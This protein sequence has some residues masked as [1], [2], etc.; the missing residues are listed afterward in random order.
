MTKSNKGQKPS[1]DLPLR[2]LRCFI[3]VIRGDRYADAAARLGVTSS[4]VS[5]QIRTLE[6]WIGG[7]LLS[8]ETKKPL[9][10]ELG[11][12]LHEG[13]AEPMAR[14]ERVMAAVQR[15]GDDDNLVIS[16]PPAFVS[17]RL[18]PCLAGFRSA[19]PKIKIDF[20][21]VR[22]DA[23]VEP[24]SADIA[25]RFIH[26]HP[27]ARRLGVRGWRAVCTPGYDKALGHPRRLD[28]LEGAVL[29]HE[30][31]YNF[32]PEAFRARGLDVPT[33]VTYRALGDA[34]HVLSSLLAG[35][36]MALLP[37]ELTRGLRRD[38]AL[39]SPLDADIEPDAAYYAIVADGGTKREALEAVFRWLDT[40]S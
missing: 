37:N 36:A 15:S 39:V 13:A 21:L 35:D 34:S 14:I 4:A 8:R 7:K 22:F 16:A 33:G 27:T 29:L 30:D 5:H 11:R 32:W 1:V 10:T 28:D 6:D 38:G 3:E 12:A 31:I 26:G 2:A 19:H 18:I 25:I 40:S 24:F 23:E 9:L 17:F 20:R